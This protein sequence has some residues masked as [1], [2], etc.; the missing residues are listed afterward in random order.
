[1]HLISLQFDAGAASDVA[2]PQDQYRGAVHAPERVGSMLID[3][4]PR[5]DSEKTAITL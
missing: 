3:G 1:M 4:V 5:R 2:S